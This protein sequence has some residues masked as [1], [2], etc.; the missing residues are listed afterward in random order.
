MSK[1]LVAYFSASGTTG[2]VAEKLAELAGADI[3]EIKPRVP[4]RP[5]DLDW[6]DKTSRSTIEMNDKTIRPALADKDADIANYDT[7]LLGFPVWWYVAPTIINTFLES[8]DFSG[9]KIVLFATSGGSK[10][11]NTAR[12]LKVSLPGDAQLV[13]GGILHGKPSDDEIEALYKEMKI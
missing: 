6:R 13:E 10:L 8:Y 1:I 5:A 9:K 11:G 2:K 7:I 4:Y 3:Y 12:E